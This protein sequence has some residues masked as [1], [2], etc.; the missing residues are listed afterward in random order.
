MSEAA[1]LATQIGR[2]LEHAWLCDRI[3]Q[4]RT[5]PDRGTL[6]LHVSASATPASSLLAAQ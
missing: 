2:L 3:V 1:A 5:A 6:R 4:R